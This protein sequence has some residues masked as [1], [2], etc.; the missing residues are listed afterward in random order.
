MRQVAIILVNWN[1]WQDTIECLESL[2]NLDYPDF[3]IVVCDNG[4]NDD[5]LHK[6]RNWADQHG[7][8][9]VG[10]QRLEAETGGLPTVDPLLTLIRTDKNLG[11]AGGNN[12]GLRYAM[13]RG[14]AAYSWLL[15]NDTVVEPDA[16]THLIERAEQQ[17]RI[18]I[19][20]STILAYGDRKRVQAL[21]GGHYCR[22]IGLP[23]HHGR[24][25]R[26][27]GRGN[28]QRAEA[29]MNYVEGASMLVSMQFLDEVGLLCEDYFLYFEEADWAIRAEGRFRLGYAPF[30]IV[31]HKVG[32]SIGTSSNPA[33]TSYTSDYFNIRNRLLF[34]RRFYPEALPSVWIV[35]FG[36]LLLRLFMGKWD[37]VIMI[38]RLLYGA[39]DFSYEMLTEFRTRS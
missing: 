24:F 10:Y 14:N 7:I 20:G 31:Y 9:Y 11:F 32:G 29:W 25:T 34:T 2:L 17:P 21:G 28:Q 33:K 6:I 15:N 26:W 1:G 3:R 19:C 5:S 22:W 35:I 27:G 18:G 8:K 39:T 37:R 16:L 36:S 12:V 23:W 13:A 38:C 4:S 30:S